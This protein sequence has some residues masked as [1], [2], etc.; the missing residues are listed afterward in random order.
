MQIYRK[1]MMK[2]LGNWLPHKEYQTNVVEK[3]SA[4]ALITPEAVREYKDE[5]SKLYLLD[6]DI[7]QPIIAPLYSPIGR[8]AECQPEIFRSFVLMSSLKYYPDNWVEKLRNN[9][10]L[11]TICGFGDKMPNIASY[12]DFINRIYNLNEKPK[13]RITE[14]KPTKKYGKGEKMPPKHPDIV[15][16]LVTKIIEGRRFNNRPELTLQK[17][18]ADVVVNKSV[19]IGIVSHNVD[20]SGDGTCIETGASHYGVKTCECKDFRCSCP[21]RFSDPN[22]TWGWDSHNACYFYGYTGYFIS[23]Y[24]KNLKLDLPLYLRFVEAKRHDS[25]SAVVSLAEFRD[26]HPN[27][28]IN[29]FISDSASD[30]YPTYELLHYWDINAVIALN[31]KN[32]GNF[33]YPP[34]IS[35]DDNGTPICPAG[36]KMIF[37][38]FCPDRCRFKWRCPRVLKKTV[39]SDCCDDCSPSKYGRTVYTKPDWDLRLFTRIPRGSFNWKSTFKQRTAAE[40]VNNRILTHYNLKN[41]HSRGKKR[42][43]FFATLNA[44]NLHLDAWIVS[45]AKQ[46]DL[47]FTSIFT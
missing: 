32:T 6:L 11:R 9:A 7:L 1:G 12:Y 41:T 29:S 35:I 3:L 16:K 17:I 4:I 40:R 2:M 18:F 45:C 19:E 39:H 43:S 44:V 10:V 47:L 22:A 36:N 46:L 38:G 33:T 25:V 14:R 42:I 31:P 8:K 21:R 30:N 28:T 27:V 37:N 26:L 5:I 34:A 23:H 24:N 15:N 13:L 20:V